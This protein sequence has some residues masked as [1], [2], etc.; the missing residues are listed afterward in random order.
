MHHQ[1]EI[2]DSRGC[3]RLQ[4]FSELIGVIGVFVLRPPQHLQLS[5]Q[6]EVLPPR[7]PDA[8]P[9]PQNLPL[10]IHEPVDGNGPELTVWH[11]ALLHQPLLHALNDGLENRLVPGEGLELGDDGF[12]FLPEGLDFRL[13]PRHDAGANLLTLLG[14]E[15]LDGRGRCQ[16]WKS[17]R[18]EEHGDCFAM[19]GVRYA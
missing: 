10:D 19:Y 6:Y 9:V 2:R 11:A 1:K 15:R 8:I 18:W 5:L 4:P 7:V 14:H 17:R 12:L 3:E 16:R 13:W